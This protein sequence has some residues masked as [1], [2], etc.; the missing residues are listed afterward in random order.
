MLIPPLAPKPS[1]LGGRITPEP[2]CFGGRF[3]P[4][5]PKP[6]EY[7]CAYTSARSVIRAIRPR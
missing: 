7:V 3:T 2:S 4:L 1:C 6:T 5:T